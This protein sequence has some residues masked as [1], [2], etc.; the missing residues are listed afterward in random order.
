MMSEEARLHEIWQAF[1]RVAPD[2]DGPSG[3]NAL[4]RRMR[5]QM[6]QTLDVTFPAGVRLLDL[7]CGTGI[8]A[9]Y[10]GGRGYSVLA[11][12]WSP[13]MV[14][15][16]RARITEEALGH[17]VAAR[18]VGVHELDRLNGERFDGIY[19]DFGPLNCVPDLY[20]T[21]RVCA[22]LLRPGGHIVVSVIGRICP[23]ELVYY[24]MRGRWKRVAVRWSDTAVPVPLNGGT[25]WTRYFTPRQF[26]HAFSD[27]FVLTSY[28]GMRI[29]AP[30]PYMLGPSYNRLRPIC[31]LGEWLDDRIGSLP[32]VRNLGD[33]FLMVMTRR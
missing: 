33:H 2:Y 9:A 31:A 28:R 13:A 7:G 21:A 23:W 6:W 20:H 25:V 27:D 16:T 24:C 11:T 4:I 10:L 22:R 29:C 15:R 17:R 14:E 12:D 32:L 30:P 5:A 8:D 26:F 1:E 18:V 3:N 19:S